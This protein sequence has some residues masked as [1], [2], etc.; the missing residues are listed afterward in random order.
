MSYTIARWKGWVINTES[1][2]P[3]V[4]VSYRPP[5][6]LRVKDAEFLPYYNPDTIS[7]CHC[8][9]GLQC[10]IESKSRIFGEGGLDLESKET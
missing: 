6:P 10:S 3:S 8:R 9:C 7:V 4:M 2:H 5:I 1:T